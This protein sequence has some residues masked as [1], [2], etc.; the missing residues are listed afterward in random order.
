MRKP[1]MILAAALVIA[2]ATT[3]VA[4][5]DDECSGGLCGAPSQTASGAGPG[6]PGGGIW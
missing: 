2:A 5:A 3:P 1:L 4:N 6:L